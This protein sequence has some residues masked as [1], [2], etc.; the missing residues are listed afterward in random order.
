M[1]KACSDFADWVIITDD[2]PRDEDPSSIRKSI[3]SGIKNL[4]NV[5]EIDSRKEAIKK[6]VEIANDLDTIAVLGKGHETYQEIKGQTYS[7]NDFEILRE[8]IQNKRGE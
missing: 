8:L 7:F 1:G 3:I 4:D 6:A 2:N 5:I